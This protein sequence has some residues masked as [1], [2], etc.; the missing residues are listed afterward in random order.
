[1]ASLDWLTEGHQVFPG[2]DLRPRDPARHLH[3]PLPYLQ[4]HVPGQGLDL[5]RVLLPSRPADGEDQPAIGPELKENLHPIARG[6]A[7]GKGH[8][9]ARLLQGLPKPVL[10]DI[11]HRL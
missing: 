3:G 10:E 6:G 8:P 9:P 4:P 7:K 11:R 1:M 2:P 5:P